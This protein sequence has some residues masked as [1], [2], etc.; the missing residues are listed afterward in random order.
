MG[1]LTLPAPMAGRCAHHPILEVEMTQ[2]TTETRERRIAE[3]DERLKL[4]EEE[5]A[6]IR[7]LVKDPVALADAL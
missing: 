5:G 3:V 4:V 6:K 7:E 2:A 1:V